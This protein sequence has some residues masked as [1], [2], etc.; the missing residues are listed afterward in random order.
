MTPPEDIQKDII[1]LDMALLRWL[2]P[3]LEAYIEKADEVF[4][5]DKETF[6]AIQAGRRVCAR[7]LEDDMI[8]WEK[9]K[10]EAHQADLRKFAEHLHH[11]WI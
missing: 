4:F 7:A 9:E 11:F 5:M 10:Y 6:D 3:R 1:N 8:F 2:Q